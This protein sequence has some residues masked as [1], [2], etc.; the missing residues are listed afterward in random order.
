MQKLGM[1]AGWGQGGKK[2]QGADQDRHVVFSSA[3]L[4][5]CGDGIPERF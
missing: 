4:G 3:R 5:Q 2:I 1:P